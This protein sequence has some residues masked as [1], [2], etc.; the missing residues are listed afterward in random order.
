MF[1]LYFVMEYDQ[2]V[3]DKESDL[4]IC[5]DYRFDYFCKFSVIIRMKKL[6]YVLI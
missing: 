4:F 5:I 6:F 1:W 2:K 3:L